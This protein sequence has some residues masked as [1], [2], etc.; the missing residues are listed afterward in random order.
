MYVHQKSRR[1]H[2]SPLFRDP[3]TKKIWKGAGAPYLLLLPWPRLV[4]LHTHPNILDAAS[5]LSP[6]STEVL[7][8]YAPSGR[9]EE[10]QHAS[11]NKS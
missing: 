6:R 1:M 5:V 3:K 8:G 7:V 10:Q 9:Q 11:V 4:P 2:Q